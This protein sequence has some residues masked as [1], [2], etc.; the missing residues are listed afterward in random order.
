MTF[1]GGRFYNLMEKQNESVT[2]QISN[3]K[4]KIEVMFNEMGTASEGAIYGVIKGA[5]YL[6]GHYKDIA[7]I[8]VPLIA[9]FGAYKVA[10]IAVAAA[11]RAVVSAKSI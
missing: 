9:T 7:D 4:D 2:G 6:V 10:L 8:L 11:Q 5:Q 1:E 3:L